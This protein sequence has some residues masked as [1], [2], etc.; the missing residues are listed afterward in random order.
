MNVKDDCSWTGSVADNWGTES[1]SGMVSGN[2]VSGSFSIPHTNYCGNV[3]C[4]GTIS[5]NSMSGTCSYS[6]GG[7]SSWWTSKE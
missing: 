3:S 7:G 2:S 6:A 4:N 1:L 5:G